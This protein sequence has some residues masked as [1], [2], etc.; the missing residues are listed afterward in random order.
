[1]P[2]TPTSLP[3][4]LLASLPRS[5]PAPPA[6]L[7][8]PGYTPVGFCGSEPPVCL[9]VSSCGHS[10]PSSAPTLALTVLNTGGDQAASTAALSMAKPWALQAFLEHSTSSYH[11]GDTCPISEPC[12]YSPVSLPPT[13][14][15]VQ[16]A[17]PHSV[18][19]HPPRP[20]HSSHLRRGPPAGLPGCLGDLDAA[21]HVFK[22]DSHHVIIPAEPEQSGKGRGSIGLVWALSLGPRPSTG[23]SSPPCDFPLGEL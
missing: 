8:T 23:C 3:D 15:P 18:R 13:H 1:M 21:L 16:G 10:P 14:S 4:P 5:S 19:P 20:A 2:G 22:T 17:D 11:R 6:A 7:Q 12:C 9:P